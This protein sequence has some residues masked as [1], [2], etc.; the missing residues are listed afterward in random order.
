MLMTKIYV[1]N[2]DSRVCVLKYK[3]D[4]IINGLIDVPIALNIINNTMDERSYIN[5]MSNVK[6]RALKNK[7]KYA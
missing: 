4:I 3:F 1:Q 7:S 6:A 5:G 2:I